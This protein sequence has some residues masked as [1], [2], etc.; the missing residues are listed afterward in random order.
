MTVVNR[1]HQRT[2]LTKIS[3]SDIAGIL[4]LPVN[5]LYFEIYSEKSKCEK[6]V[7]KIEVTS[8]NKFNF[9]YQ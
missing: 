4:N 7:N 2:S 3:I 9:G 8:P 1:F 5:V 6:I